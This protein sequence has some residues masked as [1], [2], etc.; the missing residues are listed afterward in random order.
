MQNVLKN[1]I[2]LNVTEIWPEENLGKVF[3]L[4]SIVTRLFQTSVFE[5]FPFSSYVQGIYG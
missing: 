2:F 4:P 5:F 3:F 1:D